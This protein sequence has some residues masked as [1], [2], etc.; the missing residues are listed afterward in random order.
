MNVRKWTKWSSIGG[1]DRY[2]RVGQ[3][4]N[5]GTVWTLLAER[6]PNGKWLWSSAPEYSEDGNGSEGEVAS[7][8]KAK[9]AANAHGHAPANGTKPK[10]TK[11]PK[12]PRSPGTG[13]RHRKSKRPRGFWAKLFG[14]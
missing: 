2:H 13:K 7:L 5:G 9:S 3:N 11:A 4:A 1:H 8:A 6:Q 12:G 14:L 10:R